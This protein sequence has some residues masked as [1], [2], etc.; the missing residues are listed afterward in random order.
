M[1]FYAATGLLSE[2]Q[3]LPGF[4]NMH[5][6]LHTR[7]NKPFDM[8][9]PHQDLSVMTTHDLL[10]RTSRNSVFD[11]FDTM[12]R[13]PLYTE[14][15]YPIIIP[16]TSAVANRHRVSEQTCF[17]DS[18]RDT[19]YVSP[20]SL[21]FSFN[22]AFGK[23]LN[24]NVVAM[25]E[26]IRKVA[27]LGSSDAQ[28]ELG[29][30]YAYG[31]AGV[32]QDYEEALLWVQKAVEQGNENAIEFLQE[33]AVGAIIR[34]A[35]EQGDTDAQRKLGLLYLDGIGVPQDCMEAVKWFRTAAEQGHAAAQYHLGVCYRRGQGVTQ[36]DVEAVRW[37]RKSAE[38]GYDMA[39][40]N[41]GYIT[42]KG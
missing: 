34:E 4:G 10:P 8:A 42:S 9:L 24:E 26:E 19:I 31:Y 13:H 21:L 3:F 23:R 17:Y 33:V 16:L 15:S 1:R 18:R 25:V 6:K 7:N 29:M 39:Q 11:A 32:P 27:E 36:D 12:Y 20:N 14:L 38:Q 35:A 2:Y 22:H 37:Y 41:L 30:R 5:G 28:F 40:N